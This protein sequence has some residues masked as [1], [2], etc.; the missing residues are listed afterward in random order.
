MKKVREDIVGDLSIVVTRKTVVDETFNRNS[1]NICK[2]IVCIDARQL[3]PHS[4]SQP[5][6][7]SIHTRWD[8]D[9]ETGR[10]TPRQ[11]KTRSF[12]N[13][14]VLFSRNKISL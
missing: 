9:S 1:T 7:T 2:F 8:I 3:F 11:N 6:I 14:A 5:M 13:L 4:V 10:F 12:E